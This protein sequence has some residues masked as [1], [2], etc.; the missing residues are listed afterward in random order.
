[1]HSTAPTLYTKLW[2]SSVSFPL[3]HSD[4][5]R[6]TEKSLLTILWTI[7]LEYFY[8]ENLYS[9]SKVIEIEFVTYGFLN[10]QNEKNAFG[11][12]VYQKFGTKTSEPIRFKLYGEVFYIVFRQSISA[13][14]SPR[15]EP[16][17][18]TKTCYA[19][20]PGGNNK[21]YMLTASH[22]FPG[23]KDGDVVDIINE[24]NG[25]VV[26]SNIEKVCTNGIDAALVEIPDELLY[27]N[28]IKTRQF[29]AQWEDVIFESRSSNTIVQTKIVE[30]SS[31]RGTLDPAIPLRLYTADVG[32]PGDSG[33]LLKDSYGNGIGIYMGTITPIV[34]NNNLQLEGVFQH[35]MQAEK[36]LNIDIFE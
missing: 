8:E 7:A 24:H 9:I 12:I 36:H 4:G 13:I 2:N 17:N 32:I 33:A 26:S 30:V 6:Y 15:F 31:G 34:N 5:R 27:P 35:L 19:A 18:G 22:L 3:A 29:L 20:Y 10:P 14:H 16:L 11:I 28:Q 21:W 25:K 23:K 1:M